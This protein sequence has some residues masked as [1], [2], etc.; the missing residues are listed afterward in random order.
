MIDQLQSHVAFK[1]F[2]SKGIS[3]RPTDSLNYCYSCKQYFD[4]CLLAYYYIEEAN[5]VIGERG[6]SLTVR[7]KR[8]GYL[9]DTTVG[10]V[11]KRLSNDIQS[12]PEYQVP[13]SSL[14]KVSQ[15]RYLAKYS[16]TIRLPF[17]RTHFA[18]SWICNFVTI[19][20]LIVCFDHLGC[21]ISLYISLCFLFAS[22][23]NAQ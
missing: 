17:M 1:A 6:G 5:Y 12:V 10:T 11:G 22:F 23:L 9:S 21:C 20:Q 3:I 7:I 15:S 2:P 4:V 8:S 13:M 18:V 19:L 14:H 16:R